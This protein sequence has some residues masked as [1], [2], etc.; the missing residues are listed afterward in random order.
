MPSKKQQQ[1]GEWP[2]A[3]VARLGFPV[4]LVLVA[5]AAAAGIAPIEAGAYAFA[6]SMAGFLLWSAGLELGAGGDGFPGLPM[7]L[8]AAGFGAMGLGVLASYLADPGIWG[9]AWMLASLTPPFLAS[10]LRAWRGGGARP[11][12]VSAALLTA[13]SVIAAAIEGGMMLRPSFAAS[14][15]AATAACAA[16]SSRA[17]RQASRLA[18]W[19]AST[20]GSTTRMPSSPA[21]RGEG[22]VSSHLLTPT[23][24]VSP[25]SMAPS[26]EE[27]DSTSLPFM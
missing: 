1:P 24:V 25:R 3:R 8:L 6:A 4:Y 18:I 11:A 20:A 5:T 19:S 13:L 22:S 17:A 9:N 14:F 12:Y 10:S 21:V 2:G 16:G 7:G 27:F 23:T 15:S 26:R